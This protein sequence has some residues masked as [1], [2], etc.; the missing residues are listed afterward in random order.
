MSSVMLL[1][2]QSAVILLYL[3]SSVILFYCL[4]IKCPQLCGYIVSRLNVLSYVEKPSSVDDVLLL[5]A[6]S[7]SILFE[8]SML[9]PDVGYIAGN[10]YKERTPAILGLTSALVALIQTLFQ[11]E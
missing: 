2:L 11:V 5:V 3:Q 7:G 6:M 1:Y 8:L 9:V 4:Q 10:E